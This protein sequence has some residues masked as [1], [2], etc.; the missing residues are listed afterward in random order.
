MNID[1]IL[2]Q[3]IIAIMGMCIWPIFLLGIVI[4]VFRQN[5]D[6]KNIHLHN[7]KPVLKT[8]LTEHDYAPEHS[9]Y[10]LNDEYDDFEAPTKIDDFGHTHVSIS[11][12][13]DH[14][15]LNI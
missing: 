11:P 7:V 14:Q 6:Q 5:N 15:H 13:P 1:D 12:G 4:S 8:Q 2:F 3:R 10:N 9:L